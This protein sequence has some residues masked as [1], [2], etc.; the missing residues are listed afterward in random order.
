LAES[1]RKKISQR[2]TSEREQIYLKAIE[3][4]KKE[5]EEMLK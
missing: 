2:E 5:A 4:K 1:Y 3:Q